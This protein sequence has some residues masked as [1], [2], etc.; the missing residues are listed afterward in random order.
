MTPKPY[1]LIVSMDVDP[2]KEDLFN[3]VYDSEHVPLL[4]RVPGVGAITRCRVEPL[5]MAFGGEIRDIDP[6]AEPRYA[7]YY[8]LDGPEVLTGAEWA[9]AVDQG[10][11]ATEVRPYTRNRR[12]VL[13]R[14]L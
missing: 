1:L 6:G 8:E 10:R 5:R 9:E 4:S 13:Q 7:A 14:R 11:W 3:E 2:D 12:H